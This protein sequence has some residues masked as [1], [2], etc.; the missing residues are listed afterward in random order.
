MDPGFQTG[1]AVRPHWLNG[2]AE[3]PD[4][5]NAALDLVKQ[6]P[7]YYPEW[8]IFANIIHG[9]GQSNEEWQSKGRA[10]TEQT[11]DTGRNLEVNFS[12]RITP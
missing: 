1:R 12:A 10:M 6:A 2:K 11:L 5:A 3:G 9:T 7:G 8:R 4:K